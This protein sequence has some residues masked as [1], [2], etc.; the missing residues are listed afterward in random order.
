M[1]TK[2]ITDY[3]REVNRFI[4]KIKENPAP[5]WQSEIDFKLK[6][7]DN[8]SRAEFNPDIYLDFSNERKNSTIERIDILCKELEGVFCDS[9]HDFEIWDKSI[10]DIRN[11][12]AD[13]K[14]FVYYP[15]KI[16][17]ENDHVKLNENL[18]FLILS[19][20]EYV[21]QIFDP[22]R[23]RL[24]MTL[25]QQILLLDYLDA[26]GNNRTKLFNTQF[27]TQKDLYYY[28]SFLLNA[29][30]DHVKKIVSNIDKK[31]SKYNPHRN[32]HALKGVRTIFDKINL[33]KIVSD[34]NVGISK[35]EKKEKD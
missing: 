20:F 30:V 12:I 24:K 32:S 18:L 19:R 7:L 14:I 9:K 23:K 22:R 6:L 13:G 8:L 5:N 1:E 35:L 25:K 4:K 26:I 16:E 11:D 28:L 2:L 17:T 33:E 29:H 27:K 21:R 31:N 15:K 10:S 34:I 3:F